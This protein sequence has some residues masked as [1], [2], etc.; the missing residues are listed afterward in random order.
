MKEVVRWSIELTMVFKI[1]E[2]IYKR[3]SGDK[4]KDI[5]HKRIYGDNT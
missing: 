4:I 1:F 5:V 3:I 2:S